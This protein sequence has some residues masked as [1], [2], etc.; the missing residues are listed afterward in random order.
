MLVIAKYFSQAGFVVSQFVTDGQLKR[1]V[2]QYPDGFTLCA[3]GF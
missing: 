1:M 2:S 3:L